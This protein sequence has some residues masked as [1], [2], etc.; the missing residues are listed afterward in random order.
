VQIARE[1][2]IVNLSNRRSVECSGGLGRSSGGAVSEKHHNLRPQVL[3]QLCNQPRFGLLSS[4]ALLVTTE[5]KLVLDAQRKEL[6]RRKHPKLPDL[7]P[8]ELP[9]RQRGGIRLCLLA[10]CASAPLCE[11]RGD[12]H[13]VLRVRR[14]IVAHSKVRGSELAPR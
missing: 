4:R 6:T 10:L 2:N 5:L 9:R 11:N 12:S 13:R 14:R 7:S 8:T 3:R 1:I